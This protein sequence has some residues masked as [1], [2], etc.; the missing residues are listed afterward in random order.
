MSPILP[1]PNQPVDHVQ[2]E[3]PELLHMLITSMEP[4]EKSNQS[5]IELY[6][7]LTELKDVILSLLNL[8]NLLD[9]TKN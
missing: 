1:K 3:K 4:I 7:T 5:E 9:I 2:V 8:N 6:S